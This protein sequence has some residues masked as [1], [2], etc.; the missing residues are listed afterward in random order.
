MRMKNKYAAFTLIE[1]VLTLLLTMIVTTMVYTGFRLVQERYRAFSE[2]TSKLTEQTFLRMQI[3]RDIQACSE[4]DCSTDQLTCYGDS[5]TVRY[6]SNKEYVLRISARTDTFQ[7]QE[8]HFE[9]DEKNNLSLLESA[10][11]KA[12]KLFFVYQGQEM[13]CRF[14]KV[15]SAEQLFTHQKRRAAHE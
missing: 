14:E 4:F 11:R 7:V 2:R 15:Y 6:E 8:L 13:S 9:S 5:Q 1:L 12:V 10:S 3:D